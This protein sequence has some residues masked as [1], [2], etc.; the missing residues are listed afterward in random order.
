M[1]TK[2]MSTKRFHNRRSYS[3]HETLIRVQGVFVVPKTGKINFHTNTDDGS[4]LWLGDFRKHRIINN[5]GMHGMRTRNYRNMPAKK[6]EHFPFIFTFFE[7]HGHGAAYMWAKM[8]R[9]VLR[10]YY[11]DNRIN[12]LMGLKKVKKNRK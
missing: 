5:G 11:Y 1:N 10:P 8:G 3:G 6:G 4:Y 12:K 2:K 9:T 7:H